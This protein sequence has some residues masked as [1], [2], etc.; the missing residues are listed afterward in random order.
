MSLVLLVPVRFNEF[1]CTICLSVASSDGSTEA[2]RVRATLAELKS[3]GD[4]DLFP[5]YDEDEDDD[6][7]DD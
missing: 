3:L 1:C 4:D 5:I 2:E 6:S 7:G